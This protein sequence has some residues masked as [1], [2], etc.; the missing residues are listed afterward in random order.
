L[1]AKKKLISV[2]ELAVGMYVDIQLGWSQHP[3]LFRRLTIKHAHEIQTI[4]GLGLTEVI[5]FPDK[6]T[7]ESLEASKE[8]KALEEFEEATAQPSEEELWQEKQEALKKADNFRIN[9]KKVAQAYREKQKRVKN[10]TNDLKQSPANAIRDAGEV[11]NDMLEGF[12]DDSDVLINLVSLSSDDHSHHCHSLNVTVLSLT[13]GHALKFP[14]DQLKLLGLSAMLHD[15]GKAAIPQAIMLKKG[16]KTSSELKLLQSHTTVGARI[17]ESLPDVEEE[18]VHVIRHHH[19]FLDGS[20][21]PNQL[22]GDQI[23]KI[24]RIVA[25]A[26][27]YDNLCNTADPNDAVIPKLAMAILFKKY[28]DQLDT[29]LVQHFIKTF[30]VY[31]PGTV[32]QLNDESIAL[33]ISVDPSTILKPKVLI[34]N[35]DIPAN[36]ALMVSLADHEELKVEKVLKPHECPPR[37]Y[38]YLGIQENMGFYLE[39]IKRQNG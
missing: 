2:D 26:N 38:E 5:L 30:G 36:Q 13:I 39:A 28:K 17:A 29:E 3:F 27:I 12:D 32:V 20:G 23:S 19:E 21:F 22:K 4:K 16:K 18:V 7:K 25:I 6:S 31:P 14:K 34:Y 24:C 15:I 1:A 35:P 10:L 33:V 11:I 8:A 37:V 9:R